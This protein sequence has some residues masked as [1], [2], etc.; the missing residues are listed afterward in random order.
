MS[1]KNPWVFLDLS[2]NGSPAQRIVI[3]VSLYV[4]SNN[5]LCW[6]Y[7]SSTCIMDLQLFADIVPKTAENFRAL[8]TGEKGKSTT[9]TPLHYKGVKFH[10]IIKGFAVQ[11]GDISKQYGKTG[12]ES[13]YGETFEVVF[14]RVIS[15]MD[16]VLKIDQLGTLEGKPSGLVEVTDCGQLS[17]AEKNNMMESD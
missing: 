2:M 6:L 9:G 4:L 11:G 14:G 10:R 17:E 3:E 5:S 13:I 16:F 1:K 7:V 15:G 12:G 8:C